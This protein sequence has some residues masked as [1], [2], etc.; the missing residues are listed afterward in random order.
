MHL[1]VKLVMPD[2][3]NFTP[4]GNNAMLDRLFQGQGAPVVLGLVT[5]LVFLAHAQHHTPGTAR[6]P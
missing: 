1:V 3:L 2:S 4:V 5:H 6:I